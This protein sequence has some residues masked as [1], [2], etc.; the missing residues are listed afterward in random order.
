MECGNS[1]DNE[2]SFL[3]L[4]MKIVNKNFSLGLYE[5]T[6]SREKKDF[7]TRETSR[8]PL[9]EFFFPL[10]IFYLFIHFF[11]ILMWLYIAKT[12]PDKLSKQS[13][14]YN[15][16]GPRHLK[17]KEDTNITKNYCI[18]K[19]DS[20]SIQKISSIHK[21]IIRYNRFFLTPS[22][23]KTLNQ[24]FVFLNLYQHGKKTVYS[25]CPH[26]HTNHTHF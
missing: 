7:M 8:F 11:R 12:K 4:D 18:S 16:R 17:D 21:F 9:Q 26:D 6:N 13:K 14:K 15:W 19:D 24:L 2:A 25:I 23:E 22:T 3:D 1:S 10:F 20:I 5:K